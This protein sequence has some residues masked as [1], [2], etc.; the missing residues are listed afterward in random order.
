M[1]RRA[2]G[3]GLVGALAFAVW[4]GPLAAEA[5]DPRMVEVVELIRSGKPADAVARADAMIAGFTADQHTPGVAYF[6]NR[7]RGGLAN[8]LAALNAGR[9]ADLAPEAW[10]EALFAKGFALT[11]MSRF[12]PARE[13]LAKAVEMDPTNPHFRNQLGTVLA[14]AGDHVG[15]MTQFKSAYAL[16]SA[17]GE[18]EAATAMAARA[19]RG[20][21][22]A[23]EALG[24][25]K[26]AQDHYARSLELDAGNADAR[27]RLA[28][29]ARRNAASA[30]RP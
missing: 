28:N 27:A 29:L 12:G 7:D 18:G 10:C 24:D 23:S 25:L 2:G 16:A 19:Q 4:A 17:D 20:M 8:M 21:G 9:K 5:Q 3:L 13:A 30:P 14:L 6:C 26:A 15:A 11:D 1:S 22:A